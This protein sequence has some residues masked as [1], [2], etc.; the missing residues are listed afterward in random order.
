MTANAKTVCKN[1]S[2]WQNPFLSTREQF[3]VFKSDNQDH[4]LTF[5]VL[6]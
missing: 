5:D 2:I 6:Y 3:A 1:V 4:A